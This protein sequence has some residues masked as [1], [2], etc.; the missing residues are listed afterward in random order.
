MAKQET[1]TKGERNRF[2]LNAP[3]VAS[4][5]AT[6]QSSAR[7][8]RNEDKDETLPPP[9]PMTPEKGSAR[10]TVPAGDAR[11][12]AELASGRAPPLRLGC[13]AF[14]LVFI[15]QRKTLK[16]NSV[17]LLLVIFRSS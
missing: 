8:T 15:Q 11:P 10:V 4:S 6:N 12:L 16:R 7:S 5:G 17:F 2:L 1:P 14:P 3:E 13:L 9:G